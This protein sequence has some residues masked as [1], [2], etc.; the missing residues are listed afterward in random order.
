MTQELIKSLETKLQRIGEAAAFVDHQLTT[1]GIVCFEMPRIRDMVAACRVELDEAQRRVKQEPGEQFAPA[2]GSET[3]LKSEPREDGRKSG[4]EREAMADGM[5]SAIIADLRE[6]LA[7]WKCR[8]TLQA[9]VVDFGRELYSASQIVVNHDDCT[10]DDHYRFQM[11]L[12]DMHRALG[13]L[14]VA[15]AVGAAG[16]DAPD[17]ERK[18]PNCEIFTNEVMQALDTAREDYK[19]VTGKL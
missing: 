11:V 2:R 6:Q 1:S 3:P 18:S 15:L 19:E 12:G 5:S 17:R 10:E 14:D 16:E 9:R 8:A 4:W 7:A 13:A